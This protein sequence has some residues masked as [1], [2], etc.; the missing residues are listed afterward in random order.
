[1]IWLTRPSPDKRLSSSM[2]VFSVTGPGMANAEDPKMRVQATRGLS[3]MM[4]S[5]EANPAR[6]CDDSMNPSWRLM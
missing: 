2:V 4:S 6:K 5:C 1:M 3:N